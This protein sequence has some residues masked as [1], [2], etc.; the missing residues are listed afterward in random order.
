VDFDTH[1]WTDDVF[2]VSHYTLEDLENE[3]EQSDFAVA[4]ASGDDVVESRDVKWPAPRDNVIF[5]LGLFMGHLGRTRAFLMEPRGE[6]VKLPSDMAGITTIP[7]KAGPL[8]QLPR[9]LG[10]ACLKLRAQIMRLGKRE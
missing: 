6:G 7:Y 1:V 4:V 2:K 8:D 10:P 3:I 9:L 5:E